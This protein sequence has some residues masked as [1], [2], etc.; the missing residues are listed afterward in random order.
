MPLFT[1]F[2]PSPPFF[3]LIKKPKKLLSRYRNDEVAAG[4]LRIVELEQIHLP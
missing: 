1:F 3:S 4:L 2:F